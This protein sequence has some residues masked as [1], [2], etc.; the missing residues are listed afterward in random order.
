MTI[1]EAK[2][3]EALAREE[4]RNARA[5]LSQAIDMG[6]YKHVIAARDR[7][8]TAKARLEAAAL[9]AEHAEEDAERMRGRA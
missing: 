7:L 1:E 3:D 2:A 5:A 4:V 6:E 9:R 8:S